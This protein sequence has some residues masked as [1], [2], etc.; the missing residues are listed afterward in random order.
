MGF[1]TY[2][3]S[4]R[5]GYMPAITSTGASCSLNHC[6]TA[7]E[8][9]SAMC[10]SIVSTL[11]IPFGHNLPALGLMIIGLGLV[12]HDGYA[13]LLGAA[14]GLTGV[15]I[16]AAVLFGLAAHLHHLPFGL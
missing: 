5:A 16:L 11:P 14:V 4:P 8:L 15:I 13:I 1:P 2:Q 10:A 9:S 7:S 6:P 3:A 12:E